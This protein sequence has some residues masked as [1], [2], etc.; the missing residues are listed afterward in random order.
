MSSPS[1]VTLLKP[2]IEGERGA[3]ISVF[4]TFFLWGVALLFSTLFGHKLRAKTRT[5][6]T[7]TAPDVNTDV[8]HRRT[9]FD[10]ERA[11]HRI[12]FGQFVAVTINQLLYGVRRSVKILAWIVFALAVLYLTLRTV[13][14]HLGRLSSK[15]TRPLD[16]LF[17][18]AF[19]ILWTSMISIAF[20]TRW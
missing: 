1:Q 9:A 20:D 13:L 3:F 2:H 16:F 4:A 7:V 18:L 10:L 14:S 17:M 6:G 19:L 12:F 11:A 5:T 8:D 15:A